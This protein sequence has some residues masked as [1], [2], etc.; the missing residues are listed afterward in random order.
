ME[1]PQDQESPEK[2]SKLKRIDYELQKC[3]GSVSSGLEHEIL[4]SEF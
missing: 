1:G 4:K 2:N 3:M